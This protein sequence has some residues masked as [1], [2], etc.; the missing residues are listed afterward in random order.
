MRSRK[1]YRNRQKA[2]VV[3]LTALATIRT[4]AL[5]LQL[6]TAGL[7]DPIAF[8]AATLQTVLASVAK[9]VS[10]SEEAAANAEG[11]LNGQSP[12]HCRRFLPPLSGSATFDA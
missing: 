7:E 12:G 10:A 8:T 4:A 5:H 3:F 6:D 2:V 11:Q 9:A 1:I